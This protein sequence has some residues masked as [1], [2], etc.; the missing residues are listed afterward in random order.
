MGES[1]DEVAERPTKRV[2]IAENP[3]Q[4]VGL[5]ESL[6]DRERVQ[7]WYSSTEF[8]ASKDS[9]KEICRSYRQSRRYSDCLTQA[10]NTACGLADQHE[11]IQ[12]EQENPVAKDTESPDEVCEFL[13]QVHLA[14]CCDNIVSPPFFGKLL[15]SRQMDSGTTGS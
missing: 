6:S 2:R 1:D 15:G 5:V 12:Q 11:I 8:A 14:L 10:Y 9:V 3:S 4:V 13:N 7:S